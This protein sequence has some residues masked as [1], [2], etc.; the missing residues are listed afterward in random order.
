MKLNEVDKTERHLD[1][2]QKRQGLRGI[3]QFFD[4][5]DKDETWQYYDV[6][7]GFLAVN[8]SLGEVSVIGVSHDRTQFSMHTED[9]GEVI[10]S[11]DVLAR[12][13]VY[14]LERVY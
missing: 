10:T 4:E 12:T 7:E 14:K 13:V 8:Q 5:L 2:A 9:R 1:I 11:E 6:K 3:L